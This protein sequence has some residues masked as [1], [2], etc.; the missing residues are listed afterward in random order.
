[1]TTPI[2]IS[3]VETDLDALAGA[4][5]KLAVIMTPVGPPGQPSDKGR[6][7]APGRL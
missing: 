5:G 1:M 4:E 6:A 7:G 2:A 3:F